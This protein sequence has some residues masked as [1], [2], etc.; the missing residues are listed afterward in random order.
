[1]DKADMVAYFGRLDRELSIPTVLYVY[2]S[3]VVILL[4]ANDRTSLDIDVAGPYSSADSARFAEASA[5]AGL[6]VNPAPE[7]SANHLEWVG[8]LRLCLPPPPPEAESMVLWQGANLMI[9]TGR[10]EDIVASKLIRYDE[11]DQADIQFLF[12]VARFTIAAVA[13]AVK[14]LPRPFNTD[15]LVLE[16]LA[17][18]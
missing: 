6:P 9:K 4:G 14:T 17:N 3:A 18:L 7:F 5:Q 15:T 8:P 2:G 13:V 1:M 12:K 10:V 16:N 11:T